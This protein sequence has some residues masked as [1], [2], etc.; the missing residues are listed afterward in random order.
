MN[1]TLVSGRMTS[2]RAHQLMK[3]QFTVKYLIIITNVDNLN[4]ATLTSYEHRDAL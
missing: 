3:G 1:K 2:D 4:D